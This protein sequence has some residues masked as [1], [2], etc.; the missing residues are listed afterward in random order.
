MGIVPKNITEKL[1]WAEAHA[2]VFATEAANIGLTAAQVAAFEDLVNAFRSKYN[3]ANSAREAAKAATTD[4]HGAIANF[5]E[6]A[7]ETL[8]YIKAFAESSDDPMN[9]YARAEI[10]PPATPTPSGAPAT[11]T[12]VGAYI[13]NTGNVVVSWRGSKANG[14]FFSV[15]RKLFS[16]SAWTQ[17]ASVGAKTWTDSTIEAGTVNAQ[18]YVQAHRGTLSSEASEPIVVVF[19]QQ[20]AA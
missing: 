8:A 13:D 11:P 10:P 18:Y 7:S 9:V 12:D 2:P 6:G 16:E 5:N 1:D 19:G 3:A 15:W 17:V 4:L 20:L 14:T